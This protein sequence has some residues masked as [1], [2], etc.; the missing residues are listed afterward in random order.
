VRAYVG[1]HPRPRALVEGP[2]G[3][4]N[5]AVDVL[6]VS[7]GHAGDD[8]AGARVQRRERP[9]CEKTGSLSRP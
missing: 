6:R 9:A 1:G 7:L 8:L 3:G 5:G 4:G 2:A